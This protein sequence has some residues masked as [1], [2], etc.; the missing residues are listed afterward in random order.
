M[1]YSWIWSLVMWPH[2]VCPLGVHLITLGNAYNYSI[3]GMGSRHM[4]MCRV[5]EE[6]G[7]L[8]HGY[9]DRE[10]ENVISHLCILVIPYL[11]GTK[12]ATAFA[13]SQRSLHSKFEGNRSSHFQDMKCQSFDFFFFF[14]FVFLH[15]FKNCYKTQMRT[16][17]ALTFKK[18]ERESKGES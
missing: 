3:F 18:T 14:L 4:I 2:Y 5:T 12:F 6:A 17:I 13:A 10:K 7:T 8:H 9:I 16:L 15:T 1:G 11:I